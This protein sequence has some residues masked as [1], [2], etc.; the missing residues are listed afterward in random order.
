MKQERKDD[1]VREHETECVTEH[2][3]SKIKE[4]KTEDRV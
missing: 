2:K 3:E 4:C 1:E